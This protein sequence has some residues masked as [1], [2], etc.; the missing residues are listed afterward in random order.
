MAAHPS[1]PSSR[2]RFML[3]MK[4]ALGQHHAPAGREE[5]DTDDD[6]NSSS[7]TLPPAQPAAEAAAKRTR[8]LRVDLSGCKYELRKS[9]THNQQRPYTLCFITRH[10]LLRSLPPHNQPLACTLPYHPQSLQRSTHLPTHTTSAVPFLLTPCC[11][12]VHIVADRLG[13]QL[14]GPDSSDWDL[15]WL[16][17]SVS[18]ERLL[19]LGP[20]Q[21]GS[22]TV[23][24][25]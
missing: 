13:W 22:V 19:K 18:Q 12:A 14:V 21:V 5:G 23:T 15:S 4:A 11:R 16:D 3:A 24:L 2:P 25:L 9:Q 1:S 10:L 8:V 17:T 20:T 7:M 6:N